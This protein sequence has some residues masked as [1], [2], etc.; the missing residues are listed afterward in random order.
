MSRCS[1]ECI[2]IF[3]EQENKDN[4]CL[5]TLVRKIK[6]NHSKMIG[7]NFSNTLKYESRDKREKI[8][9]GSTISKG[10]DL[11]HRQ[12]EL[13]RLRPQQH[14]V[15]VRHSGSRSLTLSFRCAAPSSLLSSSSRYMCMLKQ[16]MMICVYFCMLPYLHVQITIHLLE[17]GYLIS[18]VHI[19]AFM[20][21]DLFPE[22]YFSENGVFLFIS[23]MQFSIFYFTYPIPSILLFAILFLQLIIVLVLKFYKMKMKCYDISFSFYKILGPRQY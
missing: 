19:S 21:W 17:C 3:T 10:V 12:G 20:L 1:G 5:Q 6:Q 23:R 15:R 7:N 14:C 4:K 13:C 18:I 2:S 22:I 11:V 9:T 8:A 16:L